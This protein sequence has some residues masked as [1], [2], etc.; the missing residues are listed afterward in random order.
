MMSNEMNPEETCTGDCWVPAS[1]RQFL[2]ESF[3]AMAT[4]LVAVGMPGSAAFALPLEFIEGRRSDETVV[5]PVP[6]ADGAQIDKKHDVIL[7]RWQGAVYAFDLSCPHQNTA[8]KWDD[9]DKAF[10]CPKHHS[11]FK[12]D[13]SYIEDSGRATRNMDRFGVARDGANVR[14]NLD[15]LYEADKDTAEWTAAVVKVTLP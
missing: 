15:Q 12:P 6:A 2:R 8:L 3:I 13:G 9:R 7:V 11:R 5:Y 14:V 1:R 10:A 4:A